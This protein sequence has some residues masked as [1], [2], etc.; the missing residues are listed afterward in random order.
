MTLADCGRALIT[1]AKELMKQ[2]TEAIF[3]KSEPA[4]VKVLSGDPL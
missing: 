3:V 2:A 4:L 1:A